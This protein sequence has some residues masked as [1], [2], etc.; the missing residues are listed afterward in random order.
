M[1]MLLDRERANQLPVRRPPFRGFMGSLTTSTMSQATTDLAANLA[2]AEVCCV[3]VRIGETFAH[4]FQS[5]VE[6]A[7]SNPLTRGAGNICCRDGPGDGSFSGRWARWLTPA[8][9]QEYHDATGNLA[10][11]K[12]QVGRTKRR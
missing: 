12:V 1:Q 8:S 6:V 9:A 4:C 2:A 3:H 5:R 10:R 7:C 11:C